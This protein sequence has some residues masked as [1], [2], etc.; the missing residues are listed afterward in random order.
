MFELKIE[1]D[2]ETYI[3]Q[4]L[5]IEKITRMAFKTFKDDFDSHEDVNINVTYLVSLLGGL[6]FKTNIAII[7]TK[8][9]EMIIADL[10]ESKRQIKEEE[11]CSELEKVGMN[12]EDF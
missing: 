11:N 2:G 8:I 10:E 3:Y 6:R 12:K 9:E 1:E 4:A 5:T 7:K